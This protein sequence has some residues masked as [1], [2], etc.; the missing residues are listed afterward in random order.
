[1]TRTFRPGTVRGA[2]AVAIRSPDDVPFVA[3]LG[4]TE[5]RYVVVTP[6]G[7]DPKRAKLT[8]GQIDRWYEVES[9]TRLPDPR[10]AVVMLTPIDPPGHRRVIDIGAG[11]VIGR[12]VGS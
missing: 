10:V 9:A 2:S 3:R 8:R 6:K 7:C 11:P 12:A 1:M 4:K 5:Q